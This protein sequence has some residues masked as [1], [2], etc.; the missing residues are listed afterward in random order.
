[1]GDTRC[2]IKARMAGTSPAMTVVAVSDGALF[3]SNGSPAQP[4]IK[5]GGFGPPART[6]VGDMP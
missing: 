1:M 5:S 4:R 6:V 2:I 3:F